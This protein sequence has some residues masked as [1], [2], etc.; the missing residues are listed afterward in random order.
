M[1]VHSLGDDPVLEPDAPEPEPGRGETLVAVEAA[2]VGRLNVS[3]AAGEFPGERVAV[4]GAAGAV[5]SIAVQLA[6]AARARD[7]PALVRTSATLGF[8]PPGATA[9]V[10]DDPDVLDRLRADGGVDLLVDTVGGHGLAELVEAMRPGG[11]IALV[12]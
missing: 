1:R 4:R 11:R 8:V 9:L 6:L 12:G 2:A 3:I 5:G 10:A 7:V